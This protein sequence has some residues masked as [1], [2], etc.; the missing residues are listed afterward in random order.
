MK[1]RRF[2]SASEGSRQKPKKNEGM[3]PL[4]LDRFN[5]SDKRSTSSP[6]PVCGS[7][8][9]ESAERRQQESGY[10]LIASF[11]SQKINACCGKRLDLSS[12]IGIFRIP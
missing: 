6:E 4:E 11:F 1:S 9:G 5:R 12:S 8:S 7:G 10:L 2:K 3:N